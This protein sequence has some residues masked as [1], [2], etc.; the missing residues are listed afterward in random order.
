MNYQTALIGIHPDA[1]AAI[2]AS[3]LAN[4]NAVPHKI[5]QLM[6]LAWH[7][8]YCHERSPALRARDIKPWHV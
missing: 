1:L 3:P 5:K 6:R 8:K 4:W 2:N 7:A